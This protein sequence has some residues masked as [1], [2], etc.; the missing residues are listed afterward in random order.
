MCNKLE[1]SPIWIIP[2][3][4]KPFEETAMQESFNATSG[5]GNI[6]I[7]L[8]RI[9]FLLFHK[10]HLYILH[11]HLKMGQLFICIILISNCNFYKEFKIKESYLQTT[12]LKKIKKF[13]IEI[14]ASIIQKSKQW[15][16]YAHAIDIF[17]N[18]NNH[19]TIKDGNSCFKMVFISNIKNR[20]H[21]NIEVDHFIDKLKEFCYICSE[22]VILI[23]WQIQ[24]RK[25]ILLRD[26]ICN[27]RET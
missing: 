3:L 11:I 8:N 24:T 21:F 5:L 16:N 22:K 4:R 9:Y 6:M 19:K 7:R 14:K 25:G 26:K 2:I 12:N 13:Q 17:D 15:T 10:N 1:C 23:Y 20:C 18:G 27:K